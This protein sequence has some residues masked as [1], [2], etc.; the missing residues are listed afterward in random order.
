MPGE[1]SNNQNI[2]SAFKFD[3]GIRIIVFTDGVNIKSFKCDE[4]WNVL[5]CFAECP[6]TWSGCTA[7]EYHL[8]LRNVIH[9]KEYF[10]SEHSTNL[11]ESP[12]LPSG[13]DAVEFLDWVDDEI[14]PFVK[15]NGKWI[16]SCGNGTSSSSK[17]LYALFKKDNSFKGQPQEEDVNKIAEN[18][19]NELE[20]K[21]HTEFA[22]AIDYVVGFV[23]GYETAKSKHDVPMHEERKVGE[24]GEESQR[25]IPL[26]DVMQVVHDWLNSDDVFVTAGKD[27]EL[28]KDSWIG[29]KKGSLLTRLIKIISPLPTPPKQ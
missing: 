7:T 12:A 13:S 15:H 25:L 10:V 8:R 5:S 22:S 11:D 6:I 23:N 19:W 17:D 26:K 9:K 24:Q 18:S 21:G 2:Q 28:V 27:G 3:N 4:S 20:K 16:Q 14:N 1:I 29:C